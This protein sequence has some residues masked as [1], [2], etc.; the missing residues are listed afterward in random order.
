MPPPKTNCRGRSESQA[1]CKLADVS[2]P[3]PPIEIA[4]GMLTLSDGKQI[5]LGG[6]LLTLNPDRG[7][8]LRCWEMEYPTDSQFLHRFGELAHVPQRIEL[9]SPAGRRWSGR[10]LVSSTLPDRIRFVGYGA[11]ESM[12]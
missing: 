3:G 4:G 6:G 7:E 1:G 9:H 12:D 2:E 5:P 8:R 11:L 10:T